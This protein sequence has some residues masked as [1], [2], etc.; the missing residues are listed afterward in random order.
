MNNL[1]VEQI[2]FRCYRLSIRL[3][4]LAQ[5]FLQMA[6]LSLGGVNGEAVLGIVRESKVFLELTAID[7][8]VD[9]AFE[10]AQ[11]QRQLSRWHTHW[12]ETWASDSSRLEISTLSQTWAN[13]I[14]EMAGVHS[15]NT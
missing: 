3:E 1:T 14:R 15:T 4:R 9:S 6:S 8:D 13:R 7:L 12:L 11:M 2:A 5:N 10:L